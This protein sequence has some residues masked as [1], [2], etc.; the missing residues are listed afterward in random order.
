MLSV[1]WMASLF[2][3]LSTG[4]T[5]FA[6]NPNDF[7]L[8]QTRPIDLL[9]VE[10][11]TH[12]V[13]QSGNWSEPNTW[14]NNAIPSNLAQVLIPPGLTLTVDK[15]ID[16]RI[17]IIR[18]QGK[19][20][21]STTT[22][23]ALQVET[24]VQD[25]TGELEIGTASN[26]IPQGTT[27][28]ITIIDEGDIVLMSDQWEKGLILMG[29]T[30]A[31]GAAKTSWATVSTNPGRGATTITLQTAPSGWAPGDRIV[32]TGTDPV[33]AASDE[34]ATIQ[35]INNNIITLTEPLVKDHT[36]PAADLYVH[37]A[38]LNRNIIIESENGTS[39]NGLDRGHIMFMHT[40]DVDFNYVRMH[41]MGRSRKDIPIDDWGNQ[42]DS[43]L[44]I[45]LART[46]VRGRYSVHFHRGGVSQRL[47][48]ATVRGCVVED[49]PGWA[50]ANHSAYVHFDQNVSYNVIGGGF[51]TEAGD[52]IGSFTNNIAIRTVNKE[53]PINFE[54]P[55]NAPD[56]RE[57][58]QDFAFQGDAFWIH[59]GAVTT[60]G[61]VASG[62]SGHGFIFWPEGLVEPGPIPEDLFR[63][64]VIPE[65]I[66][67]PNSINVIPEE[68]LLAIGWIE[69]E[70]FK[71][72]TA[73]SGGIGLATYYL[74]TTFFNDQSDYDPN[75]IASLHSIF[76]DFTAWNI[77]R[78]GI[79]LNFTERVT[80][81]NI[82]LVNN[83]GD[84][85]SIGIWASHYRSKEA[86]IYQNINIEGF[87]TG[88]AL[89]PQGRVT[90]SCGYFRNGLNFYIP[91][92]GLSYRDL[93]IDG[94]TTALDHQFTNPTEI[95]MEASFL[96][97]GDKFQA[98]FLL[99]DK[100][101]LN[102]GPY[103]NQRL[104]FNEQC[105]TCTPIPRSGEG[106]T[107]VDEQEY[108]LSEFVGKSNQQLQN[109][110]QMSFG[111]SIL[112][113]DAVEVN[114]IVGG[115]IAPW[116]NELLNVPVCVDYL[117]EVQVEA[118][119]A[120]IQ[121]AGNNKVGG[122]LPAYDHPFNDCMLISHDHEY[123]DKEMMKLY[124][125]PT[126]GTFHLEVKL[127]DAYNLR[128]YALNGQLIQSFNQMVGNVTLDASRWDAGVYYIQ[129]FDNYGNQSKTLK[130]IKTP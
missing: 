8:P 70:G 78:E 123:V 82:R 24:M 71:N 72:N 27:C 16:T 122:L 87:G 106:Y 111:G 36:A 105:A 13:R 74:H 50:Y 67:L 66:G 29:K 91:S 14:E 52:E 103:D 28:K 62:F 60:A 2:L 101:I 115:K 97:P 129:I 32:V 76:E 18:N 90:V 107:I 93:R 22:N 124:P 10:E 86:Q 58:S 6:Q 96:D 26:P 114:G 63:K 94:I 110:Y 64:T 19:L 53:Y 43:D 99:P 55:E 40:L 23:T 35:S 83:D 30:V 65:N 125:N 112:P 98:Y 95:R 88:F 4:N 100:I 109:E 108:I 25:P 113:D 38:N 120:C 130:L 37:V 15:E 79:Q 42:E 68:N 5:I 81:K 17:K 92:A 1:I 46:N 3:C 119:N 44:L 118:I 41:Q 45:G 47:T 117:K 51:Q 33:D 21:F 20:Q 102:Y 84:P 104:Y 9:P 34:V 48:P 85:N 49:D 121:S 75:Y 128:I 89:P 126:P 54:A 73:Y 77:N 116:E 127:V 69:V 56:T 57:R 80:F 31:Y 39:N 7:I 12:I 11:A 61:N 59:G